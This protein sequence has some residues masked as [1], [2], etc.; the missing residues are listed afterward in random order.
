M[1]YLKNIVSVIIFTIL[2]SVVALAKNQSGSIR[3]FDSLNGI[4]LLGSGNVEIIHGNKNE[5]SIHA[6]NDL[7]PYLLTEVENGTLKIGKR[8]KGWKKFRFLN[9]EIRYKITVKDIDHLKISG[10]GDIIADK[11]S[12]N[13]C[14]VAISG[15]G[16]IDVNKIDTGK[17]N[18]NLSG[19]GDIEIE[20]IRAKNIDVGISG[21]GD[22]EIEGK[23]DELELS[24]SGSGDFDS[25]GLR[26]KSAVVNIYGSG[27][28]NFG[29]SDKLEAHLTG[30]GDVVCLG[31]PSVRSHS[32]GSGSVVTR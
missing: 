21:S 25:P 7:I 1:K 15:S 27:D 29:C 11:L 30:S 13:A 22:I 3:T 17:L 28:A 24:I 19:S 32:T 31:N 8:K 23:T 18:I 14:R 16:E 20:N 4:S 5:V 2:L 10:S 6:P 9:E 26:S 12:G